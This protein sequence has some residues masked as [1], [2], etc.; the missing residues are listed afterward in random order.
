MVEQ[1]TQKKD[2]I[3]TPSCIGRM[4]RGVRQEQVGHHF[5]QFAD[6]LGMSTFMYTNYESGRGGM[7]SFDQIQE[8]GER[9]EL[10]GEM[11]DEMYGGAGYTLPADRDE[12][13]FRKW[14]LAVYRSKYEGA[15]H[16]LQS[17]INEILDNQPTWVKVINSL[18]R[19]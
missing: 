4:L 13:L 16:P 11:W 8:W 10:T 19:K 5:E 17:A 15:E 7:P 14:D 3:G 18:R 6:K 9:L 2:G 1:S 12:E